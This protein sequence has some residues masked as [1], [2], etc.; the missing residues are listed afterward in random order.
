MMSSAH[1]RMGAVACRISRGTCVG[2]VINSMIKE[3]LALLRCRVF[4][5]PP[6]APHHCCLWASA[7]LFS[8]SS[9]ACRLA[10]SAASVCLP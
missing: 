6:F 1:I 10:H 8:A 5:F 3:P 2:V 4:M 9:A 7:I